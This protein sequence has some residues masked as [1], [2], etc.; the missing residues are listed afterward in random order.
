[1]SDLATLQQGLASLLRGEAAGDDPYLR[2]TAGSTGLEMA[3]FSVGTWREL[4][5][6]RATPLTIGALARR[7]DLQD[8]LRS[9]EQRAT[10]AYVEQLARELLEPLC[11]D[12]DP[13]IQAVA[14]FERAMIAGEEAA[15]RWPV[16]PYSAMEALLTP[17]TPLPA[18]AG[19]DE[20]WAVIVSGG[21]FRVV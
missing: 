11:A 13:L 14:R 7:G 16:E 12:P 5:L 4:L 3:R 19:T 21:R 9:L 18:A 6:R 2:D 10:S 20:S 1:M 15:I 8:A 17:E